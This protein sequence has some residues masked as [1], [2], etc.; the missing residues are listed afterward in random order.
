MTKALLSKKR[1]FFFLR[2][3]FLRNFNGR[4]ALTLQF[5]KKKTIM[6]NHFLQLV[7]TFFLMVCLAGCAVVGGIFKAGMVWGIALVVLII[8]GIIYL[9]SRG[10]RK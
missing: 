7:A 6:N 9:V 2:K 10:G 8:L 3:T 4:K 1:G 5:L